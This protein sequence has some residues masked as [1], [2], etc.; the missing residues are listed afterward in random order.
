MR[1]SV[2]LGIYLGTIV[3]GSTAGAQVVT[4]P[5]VAPATVMGALPAGTV[6]LFDQ[7]P[8][9]TFT[10]WVPCSAVR[11]QQPAQSNAS[12][13]VEFYCLHKVQ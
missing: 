1:G 13:Q 7:K 12:R 3:F 9:Q 11:L 10:G 8:N 4:G 6:L 5:V 2:L